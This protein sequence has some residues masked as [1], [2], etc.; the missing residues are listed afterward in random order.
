[1]ARTRPKRKPPKVNKPKPPRNNKP[2]TTNA[3]SNLGQ[4][5]ATFARTQ[6]QPSL[7]ENQRQMEQ[8]NREYQ[9]QSLGADAVFR[10]GQQALNR[11]PPMT[12]YA[13]QLQDALAQFK[14]TIAPQGM[15]Q[16]EVDAALNMYGTLGANALGNQAGYQQIG[17]MYNQSALRENMLSNRYTQ[18]NLQ[19]SLEDALQAARNQKQRIMGEM[20]VSTASRLDI[21]QQQ[22]K[23]DAEAAAERQLMM[24]LIRDLMNPPP[25]PGTPPPPE[26]GGDE[27]TGYVPPTPAP[28]PSTMWTQPWMQNAYQV[29]QS[30]GSRMKNAYLTGQYGGGTAATNPTKN[31]VIQSIPKGQGRR[32]FV[33]Q[34][35]QQFAQN[36][37][38]A[39][40]VAYKPV[41]EEL[42]DWQKYINQW[43]PNGGLP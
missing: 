18:L 23:A 32:K 3:T 8:L 1:M 40:P 19:Q 11:I 33:R 15:P 37:G 28:G 21:L 6:W 27:G 26:G 34:N 10:G 4:Q 31:W 39:S 16:G 30:G 36:A 43:L 13:P 9:N 35:W 12:N 5:A 2:N 20:G 42:P 38:W 17:D 29:A 41:T 7:D 25:P 22:A 24:D 14:G